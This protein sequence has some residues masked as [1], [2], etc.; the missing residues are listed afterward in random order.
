[1]PSKEFQQLANFRP[2]IVSRIFELKVEQLIDDIYNKK[3]LG[4][5][6]AYVAVIEFQKRGLPH[7]HMLVIMD[8]DDKIKCAEEIDDFVC[9]EMPDKKKDPVLW[10][11]VEKHMIHSPCGDANPDAA[12]MIDGKC[13]FN[14][15]K[16]YFKLKFICRKL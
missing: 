15:P 13:R 11:L 14:Y 9:A 16:K 10:N 5:A 12:C 1:M 8:K 7:L 6:A 2:D 4:K 3:I